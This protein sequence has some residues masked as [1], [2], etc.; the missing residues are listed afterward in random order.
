VEEEHRN[1]HHEEHGNVCEDEEHATTAIK[2][3]TYERSTTGTTTAEGG[4]MEH[5]LEEQQVLG[6]TLEV[7]D[8]NIF[9][10]EGKQG[11]S[12]R[13]TLQ[14]QKAEDRWGAALESLRGR[15]AWERLP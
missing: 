15:G 2:R 6:K 1:T 11:S 4:Q 7:G 10:K 12:R 3:R 9:E 13:S 8:V 5:L 14:E